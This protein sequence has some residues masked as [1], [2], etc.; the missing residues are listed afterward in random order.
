LE[1]FLELLHLRSQ[2]CDLLL[3]QPWKEREGMRGQV[4]EETCVK[5]RKKSF[6]EGTENPT[7]G[8]WLT[9]SKINDKVLSSSTVGGRCL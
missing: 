4:G 2:L 1:G 6:I 9:V 3:V 8:G 5:D 7:R